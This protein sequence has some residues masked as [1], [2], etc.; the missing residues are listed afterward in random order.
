MKKLLASL[1]LVSLL[2]YVPEYM[3]NMYKTMRLALSDAK[4]K[5]IEGVQE[6][7]SRIGEL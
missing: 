5:D 2:T 1:A 4:A 6:I 7:E 3:G